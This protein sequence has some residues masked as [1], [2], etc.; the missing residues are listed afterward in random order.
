MN[1][2]SPISLRGYPQAILHL[3]ADAFFTSVEQA[4]NPEL[5]NRPV[6]T[7]VERGIIACASYEAKALGIKRGLPL[8][9]AKKICPELVM[10]PDDYESYSLY[11]QR[12]F[13]IVRQYT[14]AVEEYSIDEVFADLTGIRRIH[15]CPYDVIAAKIQAQIQNDLDLS[16]SVGVS[17][18]RS[19]AKI[20]SKFRKPHG[21]T[22]VQGSHIHLLLQRTPIGD[23]W[24]IGSNGASLLQ[25]YGVNTAYDL[26]LKPEHWVAKLFHKPGRDTWYELRGHP[27]TPLST[28]AKT[29]YSSIIKSK[30]FSPPSSDRDLV[31]AQLIRNVEAGFAKLRRFKLRAGILGIVLRR[32][33]YQHDGLEARLNHATALE[34]Q[35]MPLVRALYDRIYRPAAV[36]RSTMLVLGGIESD[37][38]IQLDLFEDN[39]RIDAL[40]RI[41]ASVDQINRRFGRHTVSNGTALDLAR[42]PVA[43]RDAAPARFDQRFRG[44]SPRRHIHIPRLGMTV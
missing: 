11:S 40:S 36:Y 21:I 12:M 25:K 42:K 1:E 13:D 24:G 14:P 43:R 10:L 26:V 19:L 6:V 22:A 31:Y 34:L 27:R 9:E 15:R 29:E 38:N 7:G 8:H 4:L 17:L 39:L 37:A 23:V 2:D 33:N 18:T 28:E 32:Q 16:V 30:T 41:T 5:R 35:V 3:D 20:C 44:E